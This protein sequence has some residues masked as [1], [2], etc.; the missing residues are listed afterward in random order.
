MKEINW[1]I[2][3]NENLKTTRGVSFED[4]LNKGELVAV[5]G[6]TKRDNQQIMLFDYKNYIWI[7]LFVKKKMVRYFLKL[8]IHPE[9]ILEFI[10]ERNYEEKYQAYQGGERN[11][12][13]SD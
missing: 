4:L 2:I 11:R 12:R 3:K 6:H 13:F 5:K 7:V 8:F 1:D 9:N 10:E